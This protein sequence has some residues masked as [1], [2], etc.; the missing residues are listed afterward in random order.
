[1]LKT[2]RPLE[3]SITVPAKVRDKYGHDVLFSRLEILYR[4]LP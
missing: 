2:K 4:L 1:M 3:V